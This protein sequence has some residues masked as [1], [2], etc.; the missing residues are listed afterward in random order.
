MSESVAGGVLVARL[1]LE[2]ADET[3]AF[4]VAAYAGEP[5]SRD[6]YVGESG[7]RRWAWLNA[8]P[9]VAMPDGGPPVWIA[10]MNGRIVGHLGAIPTAAVVRGE[11][12]PLVFARDLIVGREARGRDVAARLMGA[13][14]RDCGRSAVFGHPAAHVL[15]RRIGFR[16]VGA[17]PTLVRVRRPAPFLSTFALP[18]VARLAAA[19]LLRLAQVR[20]SGG[21]RRL[22]IATVTGFDGEFDRWWRSIEP[23]FDCVMRRTS[24]SMSWRY[25]RSPVH[26]YR[27][28]EARAGNELR[29]VVVSRLA[30][31]RGI[32]VGSI[33]ELL[34]HPADRPTMV[35]LLRAAEA[36][37]TKL[38][39]EIVFLRGTA[40]HPAFRRAFGRAGYLPGPSPIRWILAAADGVRVDDMLDA[41]RWYLNGGESDLEF[42]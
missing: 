1:G 3:L 10:T 29:G 23:A 14:V 19:P 11:A 28:L 7:R 2:R 22:A 30:T 32:A 9:A 17:L 36:D 33:V 18:T 21:A 13:A 38:F 12:R 4:L 37:L 15:Y 5:V 42:L 35:A 39:P 31:S 26:S 6:L 40:S 41:E 20:P 8:D 27:I 16:G 25:A 24:E 34:A